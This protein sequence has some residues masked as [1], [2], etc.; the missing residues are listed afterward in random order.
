MLATPSKMKRNAHKPN[1]M[2]HMNM[3]LFMLEWYG[4]HDTVKICVK[5]F[6]GPLEPF[7]CRRT[8]W[9]RYLYS[10]EYRLSWM[11]EKSF[12]SYYCMFLL[13]KTTK[14]ISRVPCYPTYHFAHRK[15][16]VPFYTIFVRN[17]AVCSCREM[18]IGHF[19]MSFHMEWYLWFVSV[20]AWYRNLNSFNGYF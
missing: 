8:F 17:H 10:S 13:L 2:S 14:L 11:K 12:T 19:H 6:D 9:R 5:M 18:S 4:T 20:A 7:L 3:N 1:P 16:I 15:F